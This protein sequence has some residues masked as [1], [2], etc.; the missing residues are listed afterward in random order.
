MNENQV[1][2]KQIIDYE[3]EL[4]QFDADEQWAK[5]H[6]Q[7][8]FNHNSQMEDEDMDNILIVTQRKR[9]MSL[10]PMRDLPVLENIPSIQVKS[11]PIGTKASTVEQVTDMINEG[12][13]L[14]EKVQLH[15]QEADLAGKTLINSTVKDV[16]NQ[17]PTLSSTGVPIMNP[18]R[19]FRGS[20][21]SS[22]PVG[23]LTN[24][25]PL[26][27]KSVQV[28]KPQT[29]SGQ[30]VHLHKQPR[31]QQ[32]LSKSYKDP[33]ASASSK[34]FQPFQHPSYELLTENGFVQQ[35]YTKYHAK[36]IQGNKYY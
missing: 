20:N 13:Y 6:R 32:S 34:D 5:P 36:A 12:L 30:S 21:P 33:S 28:P 25:K 17:P 4:F 31:P 3:S 2:K 8:K 7:Q 23:W 35:K 14:Y 15:Q 19:F 18:K 16:L 26:P 10:S 27:S 9:Q 22:P 29:F 24:H 1:K 11:K